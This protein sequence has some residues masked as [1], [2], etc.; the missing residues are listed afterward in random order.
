[1]A[2]P[3]NAVAS[4]MVDFLNE[5][6]TPYHAVEATKKR[7]VAAGFSEIAEAAEWKLARGGKYFFTRNMSS[8]M[9]FAIGSEFK[10]GEGFVV[11]GAHTDSPCPKLKPRTKAGAEGYVQVAVQPYGGGV[12]H[13]W[14]DRDL[15]VAGRV[16]VRRGGGLSHE[17][18]R[19]G[20]PILRIPTV[21]I[22]LDRECNDKFHVNFQ[23][24][25][26]VRSTL[27][28]RP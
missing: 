18:V 7:L 26:A 9:A 12:W 28:H 8:I 10:A 15:G 17:L 6:W 22:H 5:A 16:I 27:N 19:V 2:L 1:M 11:L 23:N 21:A 25:M 20:R 4:E 24:H 13:S 14:M 3:K